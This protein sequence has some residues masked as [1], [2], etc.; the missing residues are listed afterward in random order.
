MNSI[1]E[2]DMVE[3]FTSVCDELEA[4]GPQHKHH[5]IDNIFSRVVQQ[6]LTKNIIKQNVE[7]HNHKMNTAE[8]AVKTVT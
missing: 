5:I 4:T 8:P 2:T 3:V 7:A 1:V 6:F